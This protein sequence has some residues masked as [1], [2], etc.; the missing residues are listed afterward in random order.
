MARAVR[1]ILVAGAICG[2][3]DGLSAIGVLGFFGVGPAR[4]FQGIARGLL[5]VEAFKRGGLGIALGLL[6][7]CTSA[8]PRSHRPSTT[9]R[10][11]SRRL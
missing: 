9:A 3:L 5:G 6:V 4:V 7:H 10:A 8:S 2:V 1:V 11:A